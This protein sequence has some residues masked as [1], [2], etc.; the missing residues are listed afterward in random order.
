V[1]EQGVDKVLTMLTA[2]VV[3]RVLTGCYLGVKRMSTVL[4]APGVNSVNCRVSAVC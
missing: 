4:I 1:L 2:Q 3:N